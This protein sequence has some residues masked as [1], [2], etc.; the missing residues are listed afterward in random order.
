MQKDLTQRDQFSRELSSNVL[1]HS[2]FAQ[3]LQQLAIIWTKIRV[4]IKRYLEE[5]EKS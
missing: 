2:R 3:K 1:Y 4:G 5:T